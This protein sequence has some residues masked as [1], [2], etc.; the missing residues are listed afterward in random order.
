V[1]PHGVKGELLIHVLSENPQRF[2]PGAELFAGPTPDSTNQ[3]RVT[4]S[5]PH[6]NGL[7]V[8]FETVKTRDA[9][10]ELRGALLFVRTEE[11]AKPDEG[12][13]WESEVVG[14]KVVDADGAA[15]GEVTGLIMAPLQDLWEVTTPKGVV[16]VPAVPDI[17]RSVDTTRRL[18]VLSPPAGLFE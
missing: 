13:W 1:R 12:S 7:L 6:S 4:S 17:V 3:V 18:I 2:S 5:R 8:G 11:L 15:L 16:Q 9:A 14:M 10:E